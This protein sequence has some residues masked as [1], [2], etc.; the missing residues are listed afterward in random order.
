MQELRVVAWK[1]VPIGDGWED[2]SEQDAVVWIDLAK[3][4]AA[5]RQSEDYVG[6]EGAGSQFEGR[7]QRVGQFI[8]AYGK[9]FI[10][11]VCFDE[12]GAVGFTDGRHRVAWLRDHGVTTLPLSVP[13]RQAARFRRAFGTRRRRSVV[14]AP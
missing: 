9:L 13:Q 5:W 7:Y 3:F 2:E 8:L 10:P 14:L 6:Q 1:Q 12:S 11:T 4:D